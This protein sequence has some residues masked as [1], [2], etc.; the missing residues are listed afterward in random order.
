MTDQLELFGQDDELPD[1]ERAALVKDF[2]GRY[3]DADL[4]GAPRAK[5]CS[6]EHELVFVDA[7][8]A[9]RRCA[10]CGREPRGG[11]GQQ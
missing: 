1:A 10:L 6:C 2:T 7:L 9:E 11:N 8:A 5:P 4:A 3:S